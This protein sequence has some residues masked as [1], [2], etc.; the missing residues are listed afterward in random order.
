M[1]LIIVFAVV[2]KVT[3][4]K[5]SFYFNLLNIIKI[6]LL[7]KDILLSEWVLLF[8]PQ[9]MDPETSRTITALRGFVLS[10]PSV[11]LFKNK[12]KK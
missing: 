2:L 5:T 12:L 6:A 1:L 8:K 11:E 10:C 3:K 7:A 9:S 4:E